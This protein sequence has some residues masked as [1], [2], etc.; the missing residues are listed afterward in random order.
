MTIT[1]TTPAAYKKPVIIGAGIV[2]AALAGL[3]VYDFTTSDS[4]EDAAW[5]LCQSRIEDQAKYGGI[6]YGEHTGNLVGGAYWF[7][8]D[9]ELKNGFGAPVPHEFNCRIDP[10]GS[11]LDDTVL[12]TP[13]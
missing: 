5:E 8:G 12:V 9:V 6:E 10:A 1:D 4:P 7:S 13:R 2:V 3:A 11:A